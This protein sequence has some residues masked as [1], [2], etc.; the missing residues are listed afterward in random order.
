LRLPQIRRAVEALANALVDKP[1][2]DR[3]DLARIGAL[4]AI[5]TLSPK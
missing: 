4:E 3:R 1:E 5:G 2:L